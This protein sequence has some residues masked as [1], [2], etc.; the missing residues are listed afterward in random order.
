MSDNGTGIPEELKGKIFDP[1]FTTKEVG[2]G[3]GLGLTLCKR[4][5][6]EMGESLEII[7]TDGGTSFYLSLPTSP[8]Y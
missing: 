8:P 7:D 5:S 3:T 2:K 1:F 4:F 6:Q